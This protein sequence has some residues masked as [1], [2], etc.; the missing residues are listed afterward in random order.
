[1]LGS[2]ARESEHVVTED[3]DVYEERA[4]LRSMRPM[5]A[6]QI[7]NLSFERELRK[8]HIL[9]KGMDADEEWSGARPRRWRGCDEDDGEAKGKTSEEN[10]KT[11]S[12]LARFET[13]TTAAR[14]S[15]CSDLD[16]CSRARALPR[17]SAR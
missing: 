15:G 4:T 13:H 10:K 5:L 14:A 6:L 7:R 3:V 8:G 12:L 17:S 2:R 1:M 11:N 9:V 16:L